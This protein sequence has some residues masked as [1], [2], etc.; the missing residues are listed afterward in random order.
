MS[1]SRPL[2][3]N[4]ALISIV[5]SLG[6]SAFLGAQRDGLRTQPRRRWWLDLCQRACVS[7]YLA[8]ERQWSG[9]TEHSDTS[10][11]DSLF[12]ATFPVKGVRRC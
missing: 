3:G 1:R 4:T 10:P 6:G 11:T 8:F 5:P 9:E 2:A 12:A 7:S